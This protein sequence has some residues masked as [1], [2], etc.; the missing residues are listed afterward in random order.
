MKEQV[1][2]VFDKF[3]DFPKDTLGWIKHQGQKAIAAEFERLGF[4]RDGDPAPE[5]GD[6]ERAIIDPDTFAW[7]IAPKIQLP[8]ATFSLISECVINYRTGLTHSRY[9]SPFRKLGEVHPELEL[10]SRKEKAILK[11]YDSLNENYRLPRSFLKLVDELR[12][13]YHD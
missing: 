2:A 3:K 13:K 6:Q 5:H 8:L 10:P 4:D 11:I 1:D 9:G 7:V 12:S